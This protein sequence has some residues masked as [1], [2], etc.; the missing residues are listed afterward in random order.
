MTILSAKEYSSKLRVSIQSSGRLSFAEET[1]RVLKL[2]E[3]M[4]VKFGQDD[5]DSRLL[6][7]IRPLEKD[8][9]CFE[10]RTSGKYYYVPTKSLFDALGIE[11]GEDSMCMYSLI[12]EPSM[13]KDA[14]GTVY[15]MQ[16]RTDIENI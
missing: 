16:L 5:K 11:Y 1:A 2:S 12:R 15:R 9:D 6:Y 14:G 3:A 8:D 4:Y 7:L 10:V 13:D